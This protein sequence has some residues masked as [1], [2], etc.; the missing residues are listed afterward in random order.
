MANISP[1]TLPPHT[2]PYLRSCPINL[3][4]Q[5]LRR[6]A[7]RFCM[8]TEAWRETM[9]S[10]NTVVDTDE[11]TLAVPSAYII[12]AV[13]QVVFGRLLGIREAGSKINTLE[14]RY[15]FSQEGKLKFD[16]APT[17]VHAI[18]ADVV[19]I[20]IRDSVTYID[21]MIRLWG[22]GIK[23]GAQ[24]DQK[25][26]PESASSPEAWYDPAG[27]N[28]YKDDYIG[29]LFRA[30]RANFTGRKSGVVTIALTPFA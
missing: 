20:P 24:T 15:T 17:D 2:A 25:S 28:E 29:T 4:K 16:D 30:K 12:T 9:T 14:S 6:A 13:D 3:Q 23:A 22:D 19:Y 27:A 7:R 21:W 5:A 26:S 8:D 11:Y 10:F 1:E 18:I